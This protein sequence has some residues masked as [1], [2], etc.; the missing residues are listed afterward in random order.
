MFRIFKSLLPILAITTAVG[1][2][3]IHSSPATSAQWQPITQAPK[4]L[5]QQFQRDIR[6]DNEAPDIAGTQ[7]LKVQTKNQTVPLYLIDTSSTLR[8]QRRPSFCGRAG[9]LFL[10]YIQQQGSNPFRQ[11][12]SGYLNP[13]LPP[14]TEKV[15]VTSN[16]RSGL[17]CLQFK[18]MSHD[19]FDSQ[20]TTVTYCFNGNT[21]MQQ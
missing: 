1:I 8:S 12:T 2:W 15:T 18:Q 20:L 9:C 10:G 4:A 17:P 6:S 13:F 16:I 7:F 11:V 19:R 14:G 21:Y 5:V 3:F